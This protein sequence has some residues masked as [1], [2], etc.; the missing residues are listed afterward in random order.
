MPGLL[1]DSPRHASLN[2]LCFGDPTADATA[3]NSLIALDEALA[4][5]GEVDLGWCGTLMATACF[6]EVELNTLLRDLAP[7]AAVAL[8]VPAV[9]LKRREV[10]DSTSQLCR[11]TQAARVRAA[12]AAEAVRRAAASERHAVFVAAAAASP[13]IRLVRGRLLA[14]AVDGPEAHPGVY[15]DTLFAAVF[16]AV[17]FYGTPRGTWWALFEPRSRRMLDT[18]ALGLGHGDFSGHVDSIVG[19][20]GISCA[21]EPS[22]AALS[23][24]SVH[25]ERRRAHE[26]GWAAVGRPGVFYADLHRHAHLHRSGGAVVSALPASLDH[27]AFAARVGY[28]SYPAMILTL[29]G[30]LGALGAHAISD[31]GSDGGVRGAS[32]SFVVEGAAQEARARSWRTRLAADWHVDDARPN[33][34]ADMVPRGGF[35]HAQDAARPQGWWDRGLPITHDAAGPAAS[36]D[37]N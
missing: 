9:S 13:A 21:H 35:P 19:G 29:C 27:E 5:L 8:G 2:D 31:R 25:F 28:S 33:G 7:V 17:S 10:Y 36:A 3:G 1:D 15:Y 4:R 14:A 16:D 12:A 18:A 22:W 37:V 34:R 32:W 11:D 24:P 6:L 23:D 20:G 30:D 26:P